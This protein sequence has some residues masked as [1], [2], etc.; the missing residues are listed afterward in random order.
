VHGS[1]GNAT[2]HGAQKQRNPGGGDIADDILLRLG[3]IGK[4][5]GACISDGLE[6]AGS[7]EMAR[8]GGRSL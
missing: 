6:G 5:D 8:Q 3:E 7:V 2:I 4:V 1:G